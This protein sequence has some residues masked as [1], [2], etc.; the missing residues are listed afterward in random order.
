MQNL[1]K[2]SVRYFILILFQHSVN[3]IF[4]AAFSPL[5]ALSGLG[6]AIKTF[7]IYLIKIKFL[8][9]ILNRIFSIWNLCD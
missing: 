5:R 2:Q 4:A 7:L 6:I 8:N 9:R 3:D 1:C